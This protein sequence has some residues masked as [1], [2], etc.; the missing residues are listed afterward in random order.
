MEDDSIEFKVISNDGTPDNLIKLVKLKNIFRKQLPKMPGEYI[1]R[2]VLDRKHKSMIASKGNQIIGGVCFRYFDGQCFSEIAFLAVTYSEQVRGY[3]TM[4]MNNLKNYVMKE[5]IRYFLTY[6]DNFALGYFKKQGFTTDVDPILPENVWKGYIKD[7]DGG[8][9]MLCK[10]DPDIDYTVIHQN[11]KA[12]LEFVKELI[13]GIS[14][15]KICRE[16]PESLKGNNSCEIEEI[17]GI[18][19]VHYDPS[20]EISYQDEEKDA[21]T[22]CFNFIIE[23]MLSDNSSWPFKEPVGPEVAP[24]YYEIIKDPIDLHTMQDRV[25]NGYYDSITKFVD[26]VDRM[27]KNCRSYNK[28]DT[29]YYKM[30]EKLEAVIKPFVDQLRESTS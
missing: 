2:L 3:G 27:F 11:I 4:L 12:Q 23:Q 20:L 24:D 15:S 17:D 8:T 16:P 10:L 21:K 5:S 25:N 26:D 1:V 30:A 18:K 14:P 28:K 29:V 7:Y 13:D 22:G 6:A 19:Q 9:L